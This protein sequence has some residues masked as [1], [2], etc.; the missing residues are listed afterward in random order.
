MFVEFLSRRL[1]IA[2][3]M[4]ITEPLVRFTKEG[5][6]RCRFQPVSYHLVQLSAWQ[7]YGNLNPR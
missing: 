1:D 7:Y 3:G 5:Y 6:L 2:E 4:D